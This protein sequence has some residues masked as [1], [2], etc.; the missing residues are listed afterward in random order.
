MPSGPFPVFKPNIS[1]GEVSMLTDSFENGN[2]TSSP[3]WSVSG[4]SPI[5]STNNPRTGTY[6][7][8]GDE[9]FGI[10]TYTLPTPNNTT[11]VTW[12]AYF[13]PKTLS[14]GIIEYQLFDVTNNTYYR[15]QG[16]Q[17]TDDLV[18]F[19]FRRQTGMSGT[20]T[21]VNAGG[22]AESDPP[23]PSGGYIDK[24]WEFSMTRTASGFTA[25]VTDGTNEYNLPELAFG[26]FDLVEEVRFR[27]DQHSH[28]DD[29]DYDV[30]D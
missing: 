8:T 28:A 29:V 24:Y 13:Y 10:L 7:V 18:S 22:T 21:A 2:Y 3:E 11:G 17:L 30:Q 16:L 25:K 27:V 1:D 14:S 4:E 23:Y 9:T 19:E 12:K 26:D 15:L 20:V 6:S 5:V